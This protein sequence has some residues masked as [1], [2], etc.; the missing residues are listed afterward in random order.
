MDSDFDALVLE[1]A[2]YKVEF[3]NRGEKPKKIYY[4]YRNPEKALLKCAAPKCAYTTRARSGV[5]PAH[6]EEYEWMM[7]KVDWISRIIPPGSRREEYLTNA[8][9]FGD[10]TESLWLWTNGSADKVDKLTEFFNDCMK[11]VPGEIP[12]ASTLQAANE[13]KAKGIMTAVDIVESARYIVESHF[14][15]STFHDTRVKNLAI[16]K[17]QVGDVPL[18]LV[19]ALLYLAYVCEEANRGDLW[20]K[21]RQ[22]AGTEAAYGGCFMSAGYFL[23]RR[24]TTATQKQIRMCLKG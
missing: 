14:P 12:D 10:L 3:S 2:G 21:K 19:A 17:D 24:Y 8:P 13:G 20:N 5:C 9:G 22:R 15:K 6:R 23:Y 16:I 7:H 1:E 18:R 4:L 11:W